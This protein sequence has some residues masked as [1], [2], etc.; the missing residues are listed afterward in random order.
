MTILAITNRAPT[1]SSTL[2]AIYAD[3]TLTHIVNAK[4]RYTLSAGHQIQNG[5]YSD[6]LT[7]N[8]LYLDPTFMFIRNAHVE[9]PPQFQLRTARRQRRGGLRLRGCRPPGLVIN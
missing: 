4:V 8:Y 3:L 1:P 9:R 5:L 7:C 2:T 6:T